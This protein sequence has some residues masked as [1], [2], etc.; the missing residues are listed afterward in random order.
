MKDFKKLAALF[1][2]IIMV[3]SF[4][5]CAEKDTSG[6]SSSVE[7][8][9]D[10]NGSES[11]AKSS[12][13][14]KN[15]DNNSSKINS[16][17]NS[18]SKDKNT[19]STGTP[20]KNGSYST[21][22]FSITPGSDWKLSDASSEEE[23]TAVFTLDSGSY[24]S[25]TVTKFPVDKNTTIENYKEDTIKQYNKMNDYTLDDIKDVEIDGK[26]AVKLYITVK[27]NSSLKMKMIQNH[28]IDGSDLYIC[29]FTT[30]KKEYKKTK[31][32]AEKILDTFKLK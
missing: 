3:L 24:S 25:I 29:T 12:N 31:S 8:T 26:K 1:L 11:D 7:T 16:K 28:I 4:A 17:K 9:A 23:E 27:N 18:D 5:G 2:S 32:E 14:D 13:D 10:A 20:L 22:E 30:S 6:T 15:A 19:Q 21:K